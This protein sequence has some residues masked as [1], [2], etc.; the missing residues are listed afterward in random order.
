MTDGHEMRTA[1]T[2]LFKE[3]LKALDEKVED[4]F[5]DL[6]GLEGK[7]LEALTFFGKSTLEECMLK[8]MRGEDDDAARHFGILVGL[9]HEPVNH[10]KLLDL[11]YDA[12]RSAVS[13]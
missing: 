9:P 3:A 10:L 6:M 5:K 4:Y 12:V 2:D 11:L 13:R 8:A 1:V 7:H